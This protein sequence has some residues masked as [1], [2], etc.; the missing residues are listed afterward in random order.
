MIITHQYSVMTRLMGIMLQ[1]SL[2]FYSEFLSRSLHTLNFIPF[3]LLFLLFKLYFML[4][5]LQ[6]KLPINSKLS[7]LTSYRFTCSHVQ[8]IINLVLL[9]VNTIWYQNFQNYSRIIPTNLQCINNYITSI[10]GGIGG[11]GGL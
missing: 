7:Y 8:T 4:L 1:L 9:F 6:F 5:L 3:M 2:L 10:S 11:Q